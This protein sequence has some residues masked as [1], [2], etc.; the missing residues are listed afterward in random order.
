MNSITEFRA[1]LKTLQNTI[2]LELKKRFRSILTGELPFDEKG[3]SSFANN[4][5]QLKQN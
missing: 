3:Y 4:K 5:K 1:F 2:S